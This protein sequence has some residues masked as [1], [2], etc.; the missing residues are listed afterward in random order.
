MPYSVIYVK[1]LYTWACK[2]CFCLVYLGKVMQVLLLSCILGQG[3]ASRVFVLYTWARSCKSCFCVVYMVKVMQ[4]L[5]LSCILGQGHASPV[6]VLYTWARSCKSCFAGPR[7]A[8]KGRSCRAFNVGIFSNA[9]WSDACLLT[10]TNYYL[11]IRVHPTSR[12]GY[13]YLHHTILGGLK[14]AP[15]GSGTRER[16]F[17]LYYTILYW[18]LLIFIAHPG[19]T[20]R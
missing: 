9:V 3:H 19:A 20:G 2:C 1:T 18:L 15:P 14:T 5:F 4:V 11:L 12:E 6:F 17:D 8:F 10:C 7:P 13:F 16:Y